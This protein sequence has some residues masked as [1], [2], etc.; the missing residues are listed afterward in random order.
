MPPRMPMVLD[1]VV[2]VIALFL[3]ILPPTRR[4]TPL[5]ALI[6]SSP[7]LVVGSNTNLSMVSWASGPDRQRRAVEEDEMR[8]VVG[9]G[10]DELVGLHVDADAQHALGFLRRLAERIA[11]GRR[12]DADLGCGIADGERRAEECE[13]RRAKQCGAHERNP[14]KHRFCHGSFSVAVP[15]ANPDT[16]LHPGTNAT[17]HEH[18][19]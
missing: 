8:T 18:V 17:G 2:M 16:S 9:V 7:V 15:A 3:L 4:S 10:G 6:A 12:G 13:S 11:V 19:G 14:H 5:L 1:G